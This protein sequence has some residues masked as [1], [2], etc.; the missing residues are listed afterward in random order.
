MKEHLV[1][2]NFHNNE[3]YEYRWNLCRLHKFQWYSVALHLILILLL[4]KRACGEEGG[5]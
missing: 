5:E 2:C 4:L 1:A 3:V